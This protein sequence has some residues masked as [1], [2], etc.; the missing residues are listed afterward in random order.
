MFLSNFPSNLSVLDNTKEYH[1]ELPKQLE[2]FTIMTGDDLNELTPRPLEW[3][4]E[5]WKPYGSKQKW[6]NNTLSDLIVEIGLAI[7]MVI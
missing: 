3:I 5:N 7:W 6:L 2:G 1:L 4:V